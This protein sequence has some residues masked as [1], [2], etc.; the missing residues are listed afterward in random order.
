M[1]IRSDIMRI[2]QKLH[3]W[4]GIGAGILLFIC[5]FAGALTMF[6]TEIA[7]WASPPAHVLPQV[8]LNQLDKLLHKAQAQH[9]ELSK[10]FVIHPADPRFS[11]LSWSNGER[12]HSV[13]LSAEHWHATLDEQGNLITAKVQPNKLADLIDQLHQTAGIPGSLGH[14]QLGVLI[15]GGASILYF[16]ALISGVIVLLPT[17]VKSMFAIRR[18]KTAHR[19]WLDLHNLLGITALPFHIIIALT[20]I[21]FA[22]HD[23]FY[24]ALNQLVYKTPPSFM[25][26]N[27]MQQPLDTTQLPNISQILSSANQFNEG[28]QATSINVMG[29]GTPRAM[30]RIEMYNEQ[31]LMRGPVADFLALNPYTQ[32]VLF[33]T[34]TPGNEGVWGRIVSSFFG[35]HFGSYAGMPG[36]WLYFLL[37]LSG[38]MLFYS[39]NLL[40]LEKR[41]KQQ[42][43]EQ[44]K[45]VQIMAALTVGSCLGTVV[46][47]AASMLLGKWLYQFIDNINYGYLWCYYLCFGLALLYSVKIGAARAAIHL[48]Q[49]TAMICLLMPLTS[50]LALTIPTLGLWAPQTLATMMVDI[51]ALLAALLLGYCTKLTRRRALT[52]EP[53]SIWAIRPSATVKH[54]APQAS[55]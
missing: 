45:R 53:D 51:T 50:L 23:Q 36:R 18:R 49:L 1:Q 29:L 27:A 22:F 39:G 17:L 16:I 37:G 9:P 2:Y 44:P 24:G 43:S 19:F 20:V 10:G 11:P 15:M 6:K 32:Q 14:E 55:R 52:G 7:A 4:C 34:M 54:M 8:S 3:L 5:F 13:N 42:T 12:D 48:L 28:Y 26:R 41:R 31:A 21:V 47:V 33:S 30:A 38:A 25:P 40:W 46:A 35:L